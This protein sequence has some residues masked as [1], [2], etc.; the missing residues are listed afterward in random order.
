MTANLAAK[1]DL[2]RGRLSCSREFARE[3][4]GTESA[5]F[6][7]S[8]PPGSCCLKCS[9]VAIALMLEMRERRVARAS[10]RNASAWL[11][12]HSGRRARRLLDDSPEAPAAPR[13]RSIQPRSIIEASLG[14]TAPDVAPDPRFYTQEVA[15]SS[16]APPTFHL[17]EVCHFPAWSSTVR[18]PG[19]KQGQ[20]IAARHGANWTAPCASEL[21]PMAS[22]IVT[23]R[24]WWPTAT[25]TDVCG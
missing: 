12:R 8:G 5:T 13:R 19:T 6:V 9:P 25:L 10:V 21:A 22:L 20:S 15:R 24:R 4:K 18:R 23:M 7:F 16:R 3:H 17:Q 11:P 14:V 1:L 2:P